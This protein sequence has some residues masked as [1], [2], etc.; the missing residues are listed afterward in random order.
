MASPT[1]ADGGRLTDTNF[2]VDP[3]VSLMKKQPDLELLSLS[4]D[5]EAD[6]PS[7]DTA[8]ASQQKIG[9]NMSTLYEMYQFCN[10]QLLSKY[11]HGKTQNTNARMNKLIWSRCPKEDWAR[12]K[13]VQQAS[14]AAVAH[15]IDGNTA[16]LEI[17][18][19]L[20]VNPGYYV[21]LLSQKH[22][23]TQI[24]KANRR[25]TT[26]AKQQRYF[27]QLKK[28]GVTKKSNKKVFHMPEDSFK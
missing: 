2:K 10:P 24:A 27:E 25:S 9:N 17:L 4:D 8:C 3:N 23:A 22:D 15:F 13:T 28:A 1:V 7:I 19:H 5:A 26:I 6:L 16:Y 11:L 14:F 12:L 18:Q 21:T 20:A